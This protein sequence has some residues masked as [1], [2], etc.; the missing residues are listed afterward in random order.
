MFDLDI[1]KVDQVLYML[2]YDS[3]ATAT[4]CSCWGVVHM[5]SRWMEAAWIR[6]QETEGEAQGATWAVLAWRESEAATGVCLDVR[7]RVR[8][9]LN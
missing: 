1:S 7:T 3:P 2:Q 5:G 9:F 4:C 6:A 8:P